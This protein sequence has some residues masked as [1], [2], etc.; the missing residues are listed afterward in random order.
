MSAQPSASQSAAISAFLWLVTLSA[1]QIWAPKLASTPQ[2]T[3]LGGFV[4][5]LLFF[6][7]V[8]FIGNLQQETKWV[9]V[10]LS[11][12]VAEIAAAS[13]HRVCATT[14]FI[15]SLILLGYMNFVSNAQ[16]RKAQATK[17]APVRK[18]K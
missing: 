4:S 5:S 3:I 17:A 10:V 18:S 1:L 14:C 6:F 8:I 12:V 13:V 7:G 16:Q 2:L 15:F 11:L 9:E